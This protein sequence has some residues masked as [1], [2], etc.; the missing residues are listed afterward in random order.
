MTTFSGHWYYVIS[1]TNHMKINGLHKQPKYLQYIY[2]SENK[3][4]EKTDIR[5]QK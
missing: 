5:I 2:E 3:G 4:S 1:K